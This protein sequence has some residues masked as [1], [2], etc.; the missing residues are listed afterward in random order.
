MIQRTLQL[1][2]AIVNNLLWFLA[3]L[4]LAIFVWI[5]ATSQADPIGVRSFF[6][7]PIQY[8]VDDNLVLVGNFPNSVDVTVRAQESV[9]NVLTSSDITITAALN[10]LEPGIHTIQLDSSMARRGVV[11]T[12]PAQVTVSLEPIESRFIEIRT[13][14]A[15]SPPLG[16]RRGA[17]SLSETQVRVTG[18]ASLVQSISY[19]EVNISLADQRGDFMQEVDVLLYDAEDN[20]V[21][22]LQIAPEQ[23]IATIPITRRDDVA[24]VLIE[25]DIDTVTLED[26]YEIAFISYEPQTIFVSGNV[27]GLPDSLPTERISLTERTNDFVETVAVL[28]PEGLLVLSERNVTISIGIVPI[29]VQRQFDDVALTV[30]G[31]SEGL[32]AELLADTVSMIVSGP[33]AVV[34][35]LDADTIQAVLDLNGFEAGT[36]EI[37]PTTSI[38]Q[39]ETQILPGTITV[40]ITDTAEATEVPAAPN[41]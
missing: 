1:N 2:Q 40:T 23:V 15:D 41:P 13:T 31:L 10:D 6:N 16:F 14:I 9:R 36:H 29:I 21:N 34:D 5:V 3:S 32:E 28:L 11:D 37:N 24:E 22:G 18:A 7:V 33:Q 39:A 35:D 19:A 27:N 17:I 20:T 26:G 4:G 25:P 30:I 8:T 12:Q 38:G